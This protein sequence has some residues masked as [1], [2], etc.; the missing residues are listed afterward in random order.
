[1]RGLAENGT[2]QGGYLSVA[3]VYLIK[4]LR[5][6][7]L[8]TGQAFA[9]LAGFVLLSHSL[10][11][12][13]VGGVIYLMEFRAT[14]KRAQN[15]ME[16]PDMASSGNL[17]P[18]NAGLLEKEVIKMKS[19]CIGW[20]NRPDSHFNEDSIR[21]EDDSKIELNSLPREN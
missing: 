8:Q 12:Y 13:F 4:T 21:E 10:M 18:K 2:R 19:V 14:L 3:I 9:L 7:A 16:M 17:H 1:M 11:G 5:G 15:I 6:E 20:G